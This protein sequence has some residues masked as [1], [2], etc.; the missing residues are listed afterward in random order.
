MNAERLLERQL[1]ERR[2][3]INR[4]LNFADFAVITIA[5]T[6]FFLIIQFTESMDKVPAMV[7]LFMVQEIFLYLMFRLKY[8]EDDR[9]LACVGCDLGLIYRFHFFNMLL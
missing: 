1:A 8:V 3:K 7:F 5:F 2:R 6:Q 9:C 4:W